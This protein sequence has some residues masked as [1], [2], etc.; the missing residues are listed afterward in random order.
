V[1]YCD[2]CRHS[3]KISP[4]K[5]AVVFFGESL[6]QEYKDATRREALAEVDL[7]L[8]VGTTLKVKP[9]GYIPVLVKDNV[10]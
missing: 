8:I 9:F 6:P 5:P 1:R 2:R 3:G 7:L 10:P 4:I